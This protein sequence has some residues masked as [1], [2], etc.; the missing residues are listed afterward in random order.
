[1][2]LFTRTTDT[3]TL[4]PAQILNSWQA[5]IPE[6]KG[7]AEKIYEEVER[8]MKEMEIP[9]MVFGR[10]KVDGYFDGAMKSHNLEARPCFYFVNNNKIMSGPYLTIVGA[11]D[12]G[13]NLIVS[14]YSSAGQARPEFMGLFETEYAR[15]YLN[16]AH[17]VVVGVVEQL[18]EE[19]NQ[20][21]SKINTKAKGILDIT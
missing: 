14:R 19:L 1:M 4:K 5:I 15:A 20:D 18:M 10:L 13:K 9:D 21:F 7:K 17:S 6:A 3:L 8:R 12:L 16:I 11:H 2:G